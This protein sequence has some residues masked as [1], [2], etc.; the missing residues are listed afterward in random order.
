MICADGL[1]RGG[2]S[3]GHPERGRSAGRLRGGGGWFCEGAVQGHRGAGAH[4][5]LEEGGLSA[6]HSA[7]GRHP[8]ETRYRIVMPPS[9]HPYTSDNAP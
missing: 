1:P 6:D 9:P 5:P 7:R 2:D 8:G 4:R 3:S